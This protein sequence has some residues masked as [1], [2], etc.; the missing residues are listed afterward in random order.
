MA[1]TYFSLASDN[2]VREISSSSN[3]GKEKDE[4]KRVNVGK[5]KKAAP[6]NVYEN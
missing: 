5:I 3:N 6:I 4:K 2:R 1:S